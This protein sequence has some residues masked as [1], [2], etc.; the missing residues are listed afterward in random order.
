MI[1]FSPQ[2]ARLHSGPLGGPTGPGQPGSSGA[3]TQG[4]AAFLADVA[5]PGSAADPAAAS[6]PEAALAAGPRA[7]SPAAERAGLPEGGK[8]LPGAQ[9][10]LAGT[11][12]A[13][14]AT[15]APLPDS[16]R[17]ARLG[18]AA[19]LY[20]LIRAGDALADSVKS[21]TSSAASDETDAPLSDG[22]GV[23]VSPIFGALAAL[24]SAAAITAQEASRPETA[25]PVNP[26]AESGAAASS[27]AAAVLA[28]PQG[29]AQTTGARLA[30]LDPRV[31]S[32]K[33][34]RETD[35]S[36]A[37]TR[38]SESPTVALPTDQIIGQRGHQPSAVHALAGL[39]ASVLAGG[40][41]R[42]ARPAGSASA[43]AAL[44]VSAEPEQDDAAPLAPALALSTTLLG[45]NPAPAAAR[46]AAPAAER[47]DFAAL[48]DA[49]ARARET[50]GGADVAASVTHAEFGR[51]SLRFQSEENGLAV[52]MMSP[53]PG[54]APAVA[55][56]RLADTGFGQNQQ[57]QN[58]QTQ[59]NQSQQSQGQAAG[60]QAGQS[61]DGSAQARGGSSQRGDAQ[62]Q[63]RNQT[64]RAGENP[65]GAAATGDDLRRGAIWA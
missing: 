62:P 54:F 3:E 15:A 26:G 2:P 63:G 25:S 4:F 16:A 42:E 22:V 61:G 37:G 46:G 59:Q 53:D 9:N 14:P 18:A 34:E 49:V 33:L 19:P 60:S 11:L 17:L 1:E 40:A 32:L 47:I 7:A 21:D 28:N 55:A 45:D 64:G 6:E 13:E 48:V 41:D 52:S 44:T 56:A 35:G 39:Q 8:I 29:V 23:L 20:A 57:G 10:A 27:A 51:V 36:P 31:F 38:S 50:G 5:E 65:G 24:P 12:I 58:Q 43:L 30:A